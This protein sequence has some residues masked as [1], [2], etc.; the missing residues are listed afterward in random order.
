MSMESLRKKYQELREKLTRERDAMRF[1][2]RSRCGGVT[3][4][5][6]GHFRLHSIRIEPA[7]I[8]GARLGASIAEAVNAATDAA[9][10]KLGDNAIPDLLHAG[11]TGV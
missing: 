7:A 10:A 9:T 5:F 3:A 8:E 6:N 4:V 2:G 1:E 11:R